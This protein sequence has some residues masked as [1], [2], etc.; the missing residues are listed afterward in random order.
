M[1]L[2]LDRCLD[3]I[4]NQARKERCNQIDDIGAEVTVEVNLKVIQVDWHIGVNVHGNEGRHDP[5]IVQRHH[6]KLLREA[7]VN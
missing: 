3:L 5:T 4:S 7:D 1:N 6:V 2:R